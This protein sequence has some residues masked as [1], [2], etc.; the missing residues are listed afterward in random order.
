[1]SA[2]KISKAQTSPFKHLYQVV[3]VGPA[4]NFESLQVADVRLLVFAERYGP[5]QAETENQVD[6]IGF[7]SHTHV[8]TDILARRRTRNCGG[9]FESEDQR[10]DWSDGLSTRMFLQM[11]NSGW[12]L[13]LFTKY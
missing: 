8:T 11:L 4:E 7:F 12:L 5:V 2:S 13:K 9:V 6:D 10:D 3:L 1:M